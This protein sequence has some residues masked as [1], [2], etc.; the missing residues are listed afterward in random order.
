MQANNCRS[1]A[2][3]ERWSTSAPGRAGPH[4]IGISASASHCCDRQHRRRHTNDIKGGT[5]GAAARLCVY[6]RTR[7]YEGTA[8]TGAIPAISPSGCRQ[9]ISPVHAIHNLLHVHERVHLEATTRGRSI[10]F[11]SIPAT[12]DEMIAALSTTMSR[13]V[14]ATSEMRSSK[15]S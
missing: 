10:N 14:S 7:M 13:F 5:L 4:A 8:S 12:V 15:A 1:K 9:S 3:R 6:G 11:P 2:P